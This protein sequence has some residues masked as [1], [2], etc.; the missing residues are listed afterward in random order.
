MRGE[1]E[2]ESRRDQAAEIGVRPRADRHQVERV[3]LREHAATGVG[4]G[5]AG[6]RQDQR[7]RLGAGDIV[8]VAVGDLTDTDDDRALRPWPPSGNRA[9]H[10]VEPASSTR[11]APDM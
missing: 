5:G 10:E 3:G 6:R 7:Q 4:I 1:V 9:T 2:A 8:V 11:I